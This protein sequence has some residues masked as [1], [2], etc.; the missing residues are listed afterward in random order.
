[1]LFES[2]REAIKKIRVVLGVE[3]FQRRYIRG[4]KEAYKVK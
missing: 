3:C 2:F 4:L 1:M